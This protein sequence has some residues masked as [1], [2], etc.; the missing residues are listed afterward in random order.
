MYFMLYGLDIAIDSIACMYKLVL[1]LG[2]LDDLI[3]FSLTSLEKKAI[4]S[5]LNHLNVEF[6]L[7]KKVFL[8]KL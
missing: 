2:G 6:D 1:D 5:F 3:N 4:S 8:K 7:L